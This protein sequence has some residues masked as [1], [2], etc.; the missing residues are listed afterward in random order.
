MET[1]LLKRK[2]KNKISRRV[3]RGGKRG[4]T[5]GRGT[6]GQKA[7]AGTSGRPEFRDIIKKIP[8][9]RGRGK[10]GLR[11]IQKD[12]LPVSLSSIDKNFNDGDKVNPTTLIEKG[13][14]E[15]RSGRI[16]PMKILNSGKIS[17]KVLVEGIQISKGAKEA[18]E[19]AGG[20]I[21]SLK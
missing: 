4:K 1:Q 12:A 19:K 6:K 21:A 7:R 9:L 10:N 15:S 3:G 8:K 14:V 18:V 13:V 17:K 16:P 5:S 2:N 20:S 11:S